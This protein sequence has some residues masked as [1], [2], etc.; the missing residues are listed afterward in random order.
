MRSFFCACLCLFLSS[1]AGLPASKTPASASPSTGSPMSTLSA[2]PE[3]LATV[4]PSAA[5]EQMPTPTVDHN[6]VS[7]VVA[8]GPMIEV[9]FDGKECTMNGPSRIPVGGFVLKFNNLTDHSATPWLSRHYPGKTWQDVLDF[10]GPPGS[11]IDE[12]PGW[13]ALLAYQRSVTER[14]GVSYRQYNLTLEAEY[15]I[16]VEMTSDYFWPCGP[17]TVQ[18][19]P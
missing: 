6:L 1:C 18:S 11:Y 5:P 9:T 7:T 12:T 10:L 4:E 8:S 15:D 14:P 17:F 13:I 19:G 2:A 16:I 3:T